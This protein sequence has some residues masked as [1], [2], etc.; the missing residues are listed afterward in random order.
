MNKSRKLLTSISVLM[1]FVILYLGIA[2]TED[3]LT[4]WTLKSKTYNVAVPISITEGSISEIEKQARRVVLDK[5]ENAYL[6]EIVISVNTDEGFNSFSDGTVVL[7]YCHKLK[8]SFIY[9]YDRFVH[10][11]V[12]VD[13]K[14][15]R[16]QKICVYGNNQLGG[17]KEIESYPEINEIREKLYQYCDNQEMIAKP[18]VVVRGYLHMYHYGIARSSFTIRLSDGSAIELKNTFR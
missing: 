16:I 13:L 7:T 10:C 12:S 8:D 5:Y 17:L 6:G 4:E 1:G 3:Y 2:V 14:T 15:K 11:E 18:Y 9:R